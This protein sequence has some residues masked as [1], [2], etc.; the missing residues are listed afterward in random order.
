MGLFSIFKKTAPKDSLSTTKSFFWGNSTSGTYV[1]ET[2]AMQTSAVYAC[3][4]VLS[5]AVASLPLNI[6]KYNE[7]HR[8]VDRSHYLYNILHNEPNPDMTSFT[9]R[10]TLMSHLLIYGNAY[11]Q[12]IHENSG[13]VKY[14][15][16]LLPDK[17]DINRADNGELFYTYWRDSDE[18]VRNEKTGFVVLP[19]EQVLH[20]RGLGFDGIVGYSPI[21]LAKNAIGLSL[22]TERYGASFFQNGAN[23][24]GVLEHPQSVKNPEQIRIAWEAIHK[25]AMNS[26][27]VAVLEDG[28]TYHPISV[29]PEQAQ[30]LETRKFQLNEIARIFRIPP[31]LIGD[32]EK[33]TFSNIEEQSLEFVKY[34]LDPWFIRFEQAMQKSLLLPS[35]KSKYSIKFNVDGLLRGDYE[36]R[37]KGYAVGIQNGFLCPNDIRSLENLN[38]IPENE[39]G[40]NFVLNGNMVKLKDVGLVYQKDGGADE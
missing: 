9:F 28:L 12:I 37:M 1:N 17:I 21:A 31:H 20:I 5:E 2:T 7:K 3:V 32:L 16:P 19:K 11:A 23:P 33:A 40:N 22:A 24:G 30:F 4:R 8:E 14:L 27:K 34:S 29:P 15:Y 10:E 35:E 26:N 18:K 13:K 25:G 36:T 39:G 38:P 6:Y